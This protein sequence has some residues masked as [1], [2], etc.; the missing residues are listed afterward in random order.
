MLVSVP[1]FAQRWSPAEVVTVAPSDVLTGGAPL[2]VNGGPKSRTRP[3]PPMF[4][5]GMEIG[6]AERAAVLD[7][8]DSKR[9]IRF[10]GPDDT[11]TY[12]AV[13]TF[14]QR[15]A[16]RMGTPYA[17]GLTSGTAA[18]ITGLAA[19]G[20]GP[21]DEVIVPAYTFVA[22]PSAVLAVGGIPVITE[23]DDTLTLDPAAVRANITPHTRAIMPVHMRGVPSQMDELQAI[24]REHNLVII[25]DAAQACGASYKGRPVGSIGEV[26]C[27]SLQMHKV[28][29]TGEGGMLLTSN[30][31]T[32]FRAKCFH[33]SASEWRGAAWQDPD[34]AVRA[35]F[36]A[37]P[38]MNFR[39]PE[40]TAA[41]GSVQLD[42]LNGLVGRMRTHKAVLRAAVAATKRVELRR[43]PDAHGDA[44]IAMIFFTETPLLAQRVAQALVAEGVGARVLYVEGQHD[45]HIYACWR[46]I[47][48]KR[49]WNA[50][51]YPFSMARRPIEYDA[52]MCPQTLSLLQ[53]AVHLD[54]SPRLSAQDV[55]ETAGALHK[56]LTA[57][58]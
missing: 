54:V 3:E 18:L 21:G 46:D 42:R 10:Y 35:T 31:E 6:D 9:L 33:D 43:L 7:V 32:L 26:G 57:L 23:V 44:A 50:A 37:F 36:Q 49:T 41:L 28:I 16:E 25:E 38:G 55:E 12:S 27:F 4:P 15:F 13:D 56:V 14:E 1:T 58:C 40:I 53:R 2:A 34:P 11:I 47:L 8:L 39:M 45:W 22:S 29:T 17:L 20:I 48:A 30:A 52:N 51:G 19:L 5:G 24:A